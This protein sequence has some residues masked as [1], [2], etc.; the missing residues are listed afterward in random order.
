MLIILIIIP[1]SIS[2]WKE[3]KKNHTTEPQE[4]TG[5][6]PNFFSLQEE[7]FPYCGEGC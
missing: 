7:I 6:D 4:T 3:G 1:Y 5:Q 2:L